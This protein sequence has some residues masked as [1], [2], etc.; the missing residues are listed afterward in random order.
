M[1]DWSPGLPVAAGWRGEAQSLE[2]EFIDEGVDHP[3]R[4]VLR[5]M[6]VLTFRQ[7]QRLPAVLASDETGHRDLP[8]LGDSLPNHRVSTQ[9]RRTSR[10]S[11]SSRNVK[12]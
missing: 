11:L 9:P 12:S 3:H 4:I 5:D 8:K 7:E 2:I 10:H 1:A 6:V